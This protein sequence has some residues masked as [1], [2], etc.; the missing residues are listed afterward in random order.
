MLSGTFPD[1]AFVLEK[2]VFEIETSDGPCLPD[3]FIRARR[4]GD[5]AVFIIE[6]MGLKRPKHLRGKEVTHPRMATLGT[7]CTMQ[8]SEFDRSTGGV[9]A[10]GRR[11]VTQTIRQALGE[12]WS[13]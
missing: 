5:E 11:I 3:F 12:R 1:A 4:G 10:E 6:V 8:A 2:P 13:E 9:K 7:L